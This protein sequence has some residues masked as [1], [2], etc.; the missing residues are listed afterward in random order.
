MEHLSP[1]YIITRA[2]FLIACI[3][4][5]LLGLKYY[6]KYQRKNVIFNDLQ[7]I[8]S[9]S[10]FFQQF[11][12]EN[13]RKSLVRAIGLIAEASTLGVETNEAIDR[14]LGLK[15]KFFSTDDD[16]KDPPVRQTIIRAC[17]RSNYENFIKL[18][19]TTDPVTL[20]SLKKGELPAIPTGPHKGARPI[21]ATLIPDRLSPG[22]EKVLANLEIRPPQEEDHKPTDI[23]LNHAK[24]LANDLGNARIIEEATRNRILKELAELGK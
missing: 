18:G 8:T 14:G 15:P 2:A 17:L 5:L 12:A 7:S 9:D 19:Y 20:A 22:M 24:Q 23:E 13:A 10:S 1:R 4:A 21:I 6:K 11:Y 3:V 16:R